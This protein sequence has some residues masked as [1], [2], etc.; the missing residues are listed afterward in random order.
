M[1]RHRI[2]ASFHLLDRQ[3]VDPDGTMAGK[4]D[5]LELTPPDDDPDGP[6][7]VTAVIGGSGPLARRIDPRLAKWFQREWRIPWDL[8]KEVQVDVQVL[9]SASDLPTGRAE[10]TVWESIVFHL[11]GGRRHARG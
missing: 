4:V 10:A 2:D 11:P 8:V 7:V 9:V 3:I 5:D 6:P 1:N